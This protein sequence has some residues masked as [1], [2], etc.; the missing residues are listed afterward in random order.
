MVSQIRELLNL[1][2][3]A[4][5]RLENL[6]DSTGSTIPNL[7]GTPFTPQSEAFR[8]SPEA[9]ELVNIICASALHL[10]AILSPPHVAIYHVISGFLKAAALRLRV[11]LES[12]VTEILREAGAEGLHVNDIGTRNG[13][14]P[15]KLA[16]FLRYLA[17]SHVY[18][19]VNPDVFAN[20]RISSIMDTLKPSQEIISQ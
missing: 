7:H 16:R 19:E 13:Q 3:D 12:N 6:C 9:D 20:T 18:R 1:M 2:T 5:D 14:D 11:C 4:V 8:Q 15:G 10:N 17:T